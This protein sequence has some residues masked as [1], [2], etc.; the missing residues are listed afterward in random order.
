M[1]T[2]SRLFYG[3]MI[4][5]L[6]FCTVATFGVI[7]SFGT[8]I[9]PL[10]AHL[11]ASRTALSA[12]YTI[13]M[14]FYSVFASLMG[15]LCDR[16]GPRVSL[17]LSA[18]LLGGGT[19]LC[20]TVTSTWQL[21]A[22]F[23][24]IA[25]IGHSAVFVVPTSTVARWFVRQRGLAVGTTA[26]GLG[27]GLLLIPPM[28]EYLIRT[29]SW[30]TAFVA[31]GALAFVINFAVGIFMKPNP[32]DIG[33]KALGYGEQPVQT[34]ALP[35]RDFTMAEI[36]RSRAFWVVYFTAVFCYGAEQML[37][38]HLVPYCA[39][40][41]IAAAQASF[42][43]SCL[44]IGTIAGRVGMGWLSDRIGR[45]TTLMICCALQAVTTF[46]LLAI[47]GPS[48]L[49]LVMLLVGFGYGGWA[50]MNVVVLSDFFGMKN[51]GKAMGVYLTN[52]VTGS[53]LGPLLA[54]AIFDATQSYFL[55]IIFAGVTCAI[56]FVMAFSIRSQKPA[57]G[58]TAAG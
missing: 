29:Y 37:V 8:F 14:A 35:I 20:S 31:L 58:V 6:G 44:G 55:A 22:L 47:S 56:P 9:K 1:T 57:F 25:G 27:F 33:L 7:S 36:L 42:G 16:L 21:Y 23:G 17:W 40:I 39:T 32:E 30:Q 41:G 53:F 11:N 24:V 34:A 2:K 45:V 38:V 13:E 15:W 48:V 19:A 26:C 49:Y 43:L 3:W 46:A 52:G 12:A 28:S 18:V 50:V 54:G 5:F 51:L 10:E 4:V